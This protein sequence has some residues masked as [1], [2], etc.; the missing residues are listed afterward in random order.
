MQVRRLRHHAGAPVRIGR[1]IGLGQVAAQ[2]L[3]AVERG[4]VVYING[5]VNRAVWFVAK[6]LPDRLGLMLMQRQSRRFRK[7]H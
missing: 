4:D 2:G 1:A 3:D 5:R 7:Q 6:H